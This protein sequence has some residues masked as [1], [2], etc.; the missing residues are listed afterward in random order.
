MSIPQLIIREIFHRKLNFVLGALAMIT[1]VALFVSFFT[2]SEA[3]NRETIRLTRDMG[4]NLRIIPR[5]T[6]M[7]AFWATGF[8]D[9]YMPEDYVLRFAGHEDFS[10]AHL[11]A[12][13]H[14]KI[15][16]RGR[17]II[18][19]GIAPEIEPS[20]RP[21]SPMSQIIEP[22]TVTV[23]F[24]P[25]NA[26]SLKQ[27]DR[28]DI[29]GRSLMVARTLPETG[30]DEDIRIYTRL[31]D[32]QEILQLQ[33]RINEIKALNC[34][35]LISDED[36]PLDILRRQLNQVLPEAKVIMNRTI[37]VARERQRLMFERYFALIMPLV[38]VVCG[39]W[40][41]TLAMMNVKDRKQ[42]IGVLR[43]LGYGSG[44]IA[45]L[46]LGKAVLLGL[47][48][49]VIGFYAGTLITLKYGPGIFKVTAGSIEPI[50]SL[51]LWSLLIAP[52]FAAL[53]TFIPAMMAITQD[54]ARTLREE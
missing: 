3:S 1:A 32:A 6:D 26:L 14:K 37:A 4:F 27:G 7:E 35:C 34:L 21:K 29:L 52:A 20:G 30:S 39:V 43:A 53:S 22:G 42:E 38:L 2:T 12:T 19:T 16:W 10:Y 15:T 8:S 28:V 45:G 11:T 23:G 41:G 48:G 5:E 9:Y 24:E 51:L 50:Y 49:A 47:A 54:P 33:G 46:F 25:A 40:I 17:V 36:D 31:E 13:L 18:L 44:K